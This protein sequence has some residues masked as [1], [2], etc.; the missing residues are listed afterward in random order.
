MRLLIAGGGTGGHLFPGI[1]LAEEVVTR[2]RGNEVLFVGTARGLEVRAV[3]KAGFP[4][5]LIQATGVKGRGLSGWIAGLLRIPAA[6]LQSA[7]ILRRFDPDVVV[8]VGGYASFPVVLAAWLMRIPTAVQEQNAMPG[9]TNRLL[10]RVARAVFV[11]FDEARARFPSSKVHQVGNPVRRALLENFLRPEG[12]HERFQLLVFGGS[13][14]ARAINR[15]MVQ[16]AAQLRDIH[17]LHQ[18]G[19]RDVE[20]TRRGYEA[21]GA[22]AEVVEFIDDMS[23]AY[24]RADLVVCRAG[25]TTISELTVCHRAAILVPFPHAA[26]DHQVVNARALAGRGA[27]VMLLESELT[28]ERL[29]AEILRLAGDPAVRRRME[30][31]AG[32]LGRPEAAREIADVC[33]Q[34]AGSR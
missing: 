24:A 30:R 22:D 1:A 32:S 26:D 33:A 21:A 9:L 7:R 8:G 19:A 6:L 13:Q 14:G 27:A 3:P 29:A 31:A 34:L 23:G 11:A 17:I 16:A 28:P 25:A 10:S 15:T 18:T 20:E 4:L 12:H 5:E 2:Q